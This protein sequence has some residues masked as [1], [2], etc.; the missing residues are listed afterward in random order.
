MIKRALICALLAVAM[1]C[2]GTAVY[3]QTQQGGMA[4]EGGPHRPMSPDQRLQHMTRQLNLNEDQ[5]QKIRPLLES[6][7][8]Q[9]Q[10][11]HQDTSVSQ[12]ERRSR[13]QQIHQSTNEQIKNV[14]NPD[15]QKKFEEMQ[16]RHMG[17]HS[18]GMGHS[19]APQ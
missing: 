13:M 4:Q 10:S 16:S 14:L 15:Q 17:P 12:Q 5:Q 3:A 6:E 9:M 8:Q 11:L 2:C 7:Q 1:A 18:G 19:Q